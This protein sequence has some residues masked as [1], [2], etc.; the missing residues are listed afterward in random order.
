MQP[1]QRE[2]LQ[3]TT[4]KA[5]LIERGDKAEQTRD[6]PLTQEEFLIGR[7][8]DCDLRLRVN[9][10]SRHHCMIRL[11]QQEA[12]VVDLGS[13]NGTFVNGKRVRS[14][15]A[16]HSGDELKVGSATFVVELG[17]HEAIDFDTS[18]GVDPFTAT[19][20]L[21]GKPIPKP[22]TPGPAGSASP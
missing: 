19:I 16:L 11:T 9:S 13:S 21:P 15:T 2:L 3:E 20:K 1:G 6:I 4:M 5:R 22:D 8:T 7:G 14:Q 12:T 10:I 18:A 17:D